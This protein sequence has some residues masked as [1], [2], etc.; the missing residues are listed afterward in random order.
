M[1]DIHCIRAI[2]TPDKH[3]EE[4]ES[5][6]PDPEHAVS[7]TIVAFADDAEH[8]IF[9]DETGKLRRAWLR[10]FSDCVFVTL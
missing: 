8:A 10:H 7:V 9:I 3:D 4:T 2:Y 5:G 1:L 6:K